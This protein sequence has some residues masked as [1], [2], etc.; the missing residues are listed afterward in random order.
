VQVAVQGATH[1]TPRPPRTTTRAALSFYIGARYLTV[2]STVKGT[3]RTPNAVRQ[4]EEMDLFF[5]GPTT[6]QRAVHPCNPMH[7][8]ARGFCKKR[9]LAA[10]LDVMLVGKGRPAGERGGPSPSSS[11][12]LQLVGVLGRGR[13]ARVAAAAGGGG[14]TGGT[15][16][17]LRRV[18]LFRFDSGQPMVGRVG[19]GLSRH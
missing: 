10:G 12:F 13:C 9:D 11:G 1:H 19:A 4:S 3:R 14:K 7:A 8:R 2:Y 17:L 16:G 15:R 6:G 5:L 18:G